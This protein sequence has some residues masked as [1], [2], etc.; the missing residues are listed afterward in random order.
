MI[1]PVVVAGSQSNAQQPEAGLA[2]YLQPDLPEAQLPAIL[3]PTQVN[4]SA[5]ESRWR[6]NKT[7]S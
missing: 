2:R 3:L 4:L 7:W 6:M 1:D 5:Q